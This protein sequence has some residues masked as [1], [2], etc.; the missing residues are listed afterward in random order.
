MKKTAL[1]KKEIEIIVDVIC[2]K[3]GKS[4]KEAEP[5]DMVDYC[6][7]IEVTVSG[8]YFSPALN[9]GT[10]YTFSMCE[11]CLK[12]LFETFKIEPKLSGYM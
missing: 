7:L 10:H 2:N 6:G 11:H 1:M 4:C 12:E 9:D 3:C 8:G 5:V